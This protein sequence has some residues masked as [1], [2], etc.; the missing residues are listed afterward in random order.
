MKHILAYSAF[1]VFVIAFFSFFSV[2][3]HYSDAATWYGLIDNILSSYVFVVFLIAVYFIEKAIKNRN[4]DR[5]KLSQDYEYLANKYS[6]DALIDADCGKYP[7]ADLGECNI[8]LYDVNGETSYEDIVIQD[9]QKM[10]S[11]PNIIENHFFDILKVHGTSTIYNNTNVRIRDMFV[12]DGKL[13]IDSERTYYYYS[14]VT[15]RA[16]DYDWKAEGVCVR[17]LFEPGPRLTPLKNSALSN[18]LGFNGFVL[19]SDGYVVFVKRKA[20]VS[21]G[22]RTYGDSIGASLKSKYALDKDGLFTVEGLKNSIISEIEDELKIA[23]NDIQDV[24]IIRAYRDAV[25]CGKPQLLF[26]AKSSLDALSIQKGFSGTDLFKNLIS[27]SSEEKMIIDGNKLV[28][29]KAEDVG[30]L[31][32]KMNGIAMEG[33]GFFEFDRSGGKHYLEEQFLNMVPSA[34]SCVV[35]YRDW[36]NKYGKL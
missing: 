14:M 18:H 21:I 20:D 29:L 34:S 30:K 24:V 9:E 2:K 25:E 22:K 1:A 33:N 8:C 4:E 3:E 27:G 35:M 11:L 31:T 6:A 12:K 13:H 19:S 5:E 26:A 23:K 15:N 36:L 17:E 16:S 32:F 7:V 10:Y 28:W